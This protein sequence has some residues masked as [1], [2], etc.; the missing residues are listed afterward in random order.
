MLS[1]IIRFF[2]GYIEFYA[3]GIETEKFYT[4]CSKNGIEFFEPKKAEY[5]LF[6][7]TDLKNY[8]KLRIP[9]RKNGLKLKIIKKHGFYYFAKQNRCKRRCLGQ[10]ERG[11]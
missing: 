1:D 6:L 11:G 2:K 4:F 8:K 3:E 10:G 9:A 7:K 5:K